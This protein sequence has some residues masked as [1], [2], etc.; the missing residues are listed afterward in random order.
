MYVSINHY[1]TIKK[2]LFQFVSDSVMPHSINYYA[3]VQISRET[4]KPI[5]KSRFV[6]SFFTQPFQP[7][8]CCSLLFTTFHVFPTHFS[9]RRRDHIKARTRAL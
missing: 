3:E 9:P 8:H 1:R 5:I 7:T 6:S 2:H 4:K